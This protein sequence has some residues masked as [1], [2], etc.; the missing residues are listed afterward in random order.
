MDNLHQSHVEHVRNMMTKALDDVG[1]TRM[2]VFSG[3]WIYPDYGDIPYPFKPN[4]VFALLVPELALPDCW[5]LWETGKRPQLLVMQKES[6]WQTCFKFA[7]YAWLLHFDVVE[8]SDF[9]QIQQ[10]IH[11]FSPDVFVGKASQVMEGWRVGESNPPLLL[12]SL[13]WHRSIKSP[14]E[15]YCISQANQLSAAGHS[16]AKC[17][18]DAGGSEFD[19]KLSFERACG[20]AESDLAYPSVVARNDHASVLHYN[21]Y[22]KNTSA[23]PLSLLIDAGAT[24]AGY[25]AD[26]TRTYAFSDGFY[27][28]V[29]DALNDLQQRIVATAQVGKS[30]R[31]FELDAQQMLVGLLNHIGLI[32]MSVDHVFTSGL[33]YYF[34]PHGLSHFLG[35]QVH[36]PG[37]QQ[38]SP[39][40]GQAVIDCAFPTL[41]SV[42]TMEAGQI[43]T[44]EPGLYFNN[45]LLAKL[46]NSI[47]GKQ[48]NWEQ[49]DCLQ[50]YGGIRIEDNVLLQA[51]GPVNLTRKAFASYSSEKYS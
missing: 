31:T 20:I 9:S 15:Q 36:D 25:A 40:G 48:V 47:V 13:N 2:L 10:H 14:F 42:R 51:G 26:I 33:L 4:P 22:S 46:R 41:K 49:V 19:I 38:V 18:F 32:N 17:V 11:A 29:I 12:A 39:S 45:I 30:F 7:D 16:A 23:A 34:M 5:V 28:D 3:S 37:W 27:A 24:V 1:A 44:V 6:F 8:C 35:L 21:Q 43:I 50:A